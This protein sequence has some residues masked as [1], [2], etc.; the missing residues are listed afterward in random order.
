MTQNRTV[1][2]LSI[3]RAG[4]KLTAVSMHP[5]RTYYHI[6]LKDK[7]SDCSLKTWPFDPMLQVA[8]HI[9]N[10]SFNLLKLLVT[11]WFHK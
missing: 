6:Y 10:G 2:Q 1:F 7:I 9:S 4:Y 3:H 11:I 8:K 5:T